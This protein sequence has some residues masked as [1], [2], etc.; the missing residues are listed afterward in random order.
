MTIPRLHVPDDLSPGAAVA[1]APEAAHYLLH[2]MR[3]KA[4]DPVRVFNGRDGEWDA[5]VSEAARKTAEL[6]IGAQRREQ[7]SVPDLHLLFAPL[8]KTRTDFVVEKAT[9]LGA[10][11][12]RP[13]FTARTAAERV[14]VDRL[15]ALAKEAAEQTERLDVP[16]VRAPEKLEMVLS[17]WPE[18]DLG[19]RLLFCDEAAGG[20]DTPW[21][22]GAGADATALAALT[23]AGPG[24]WAVL[25]GPEGGFDAAERAAIR[26]LGFAVPVSLGPRVLRADTAAV[27][28]LTLWQ[29]ALGDWR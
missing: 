24:P 3:L 8:K 6:A 5:A 10:A 15:A 1:L 7:A 19:R 18:T 26:A 17:R 29:A 11:V 28:A 4:G 22:H 9:E 14:R 20:R 25:I 27:A 21:D 12:L 2:V 23:A 13:V 16:D